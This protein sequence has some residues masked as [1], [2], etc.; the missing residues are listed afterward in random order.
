MMAVYGKETDRVD[1]ENRDTAQGS[2]HGVPADH[3]GAGKQADASSNLADPDTPSEG[4]DTVEEER[5]IARKH[6]DP[7]RGDKVVDG[8]DRV[9]TEEGGNPQERCPWPSPAAR[10]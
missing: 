3:D 9:S 1:N 5:E 6:A 2:G 4:E 8:G 7:S 10:A